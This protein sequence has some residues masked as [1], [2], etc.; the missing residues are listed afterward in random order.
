MCQGLHHSFLH[1]PAKEP[2]PSNFTLP[3]NVKAPSHL[4]TSIKP[5]S[6]LMTCRVMV[7]SPRGLSA[8]ARG[9]LDSA[10]S[11]S[12]IS[13]RLAQGL[14]LPRTHETLSFSGVAG[15]S[16]K[17]RT[18]Q[19]TTF[20]ISSTS[21]GGEMI[22]VSAIIVPKVTCDLPTQTVAYDP[23]WGHLKSITLADPEFGRPDKI[24]LLLG[25]DIYAEV[26][27]H[28]RRVGM[29]GSPTAFETSFGWVLAGK[30]GCDI[31]TNHH[32]ITL[33]T[34]VLLNDDILQKFWEVEERITNTPILSA[35]ERYVVKHF[36]DN[37]MR[38]PDGR[39]VV[40]LPKKLDAKPLGESRSTAVQRFLSLEQS[41]RARE[42]FDQFNEC[43][44]EYL[45]MGHAE[46][47]PESA[48][49]SS[50]EN[51]FYLPMHVV[52]KETSSTTKLRVVFD[53]S[54]K[55]DT[56]VS[57]NDQLLV[58]PTVH[59][60]LLD[61]LLR[62]RI[63]RVALTTDVSR[64]YRAVVLPDSDRDL[65]RFV[66]RSQ[67]HEPLK[68]YRM[69]RV[70]FGVSASSFIANMCVKQNSLD[71]AA[72]YP[73]AAKAVDDSFYVD[74][75]LTGADSIES[76]IRLQKE[77]QSL[78][79]CAGFLL[80]KWNSSEATVLEQIPTEL[81]DL[82]P[83]Q[84]ISVA[85]TYTRTLGVEW[86]ATT[87]HFRLTIGSMPQ[88]HILTKRSLVSDVAKTFDVLGWFSPSIILMKIL[89][90]Q[91]WEMKIGWDD[92]VSDEIHA[93]WKHWTS[94][95]QM[96][97]TKH[98]PRCYYPKD[99][100]IVSTQIHGFSDASEAAYAGVVYLRM[101]DSADNTHVSL[102][103]SKSRV[104]PIKRV[105]IPRLELCG[106]HLLTDLVHHVKDIPCI[107]APQMY[108]V[109]LTAPSY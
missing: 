84:E 32:A 6:L 5:N 89:L 14:N 19:V 54:A 102:V 46:E 45:T 12:F 106:A 1:L 65:H 95:L 99:A 59:S 11:V 80:R 15:L 100:R 93:V 58:G 67:V 73:L 13:E 38:D 87:D 18:Q 47:V 66:W 48:L 21:P 103:T 50:L 28:G 17:S 104:A 2:T 27:M 51:T 75:G 77:L 30:P 24:D 33:H 26:M 78:F 82:S 96:L 62:F 39:Y 10:S 44:Q 90:Q 37:H 34:S 40:P 25:V 83:T 105:T 69:T 91:T 20:T 53:A 107:S 16:H 76:V 92:P 22:S 70:A 55:S 64:M 98:L 49:N 8:Q 31:I 3:P 79:S 94:E 42:Q 63:H 85:D 36:Q 61:V 109:G 41:L 9:L 60:S 72:D 29:T 4:T 23:R 56:G 74:D 57:L 88:L 52:H 71:H 43:I 35:E 7:T 86:N 101:T 81:K 108:S 68:D 97:S